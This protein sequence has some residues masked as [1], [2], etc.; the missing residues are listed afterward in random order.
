VRLIAWRGL[1]PATLAQCQALRA[2]AGRL[3]TDLVTLHA[4]ARA[5]GHWLSA[6]ELEQATKGG[7]Y[8]LHSQSVQALCQKL[9]ANVETT[10][11]LRRREWAETGHIQTAYPHHATAYQTVVWKDQALH[12]LPSGQ[13]RLPTG[14]QRPP[15]LLPLPEEYQRAN[16][17]RAELTWRADHYELCLTLETGEALPPPLPTGEVAGV[18]LGEVHVAAVT[19]TKRHALVV[20]GRQLRA[21]KQWRNKVHSLLQKQL[22]R[23]HPAH[24]A[25]SDSTGVQ[26]R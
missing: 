2:E 10:T 11:E 5:Q 16:L 3:W 21:C 14:G 9:A 25:P 15:L 19:T 12:L 20:S 24:D 6:S 8:L 22:S 13:L 17:R 7:Q 23:C 1:S 26:P 4:Q 18:D